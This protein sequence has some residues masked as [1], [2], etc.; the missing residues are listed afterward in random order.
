MAPLINTAVNILKTSAWIKPTNTSNI[1]NG[2]EANIGTK[3]ATIV[4]RTSPAK[5]LPKSRKEKERTFENSDMISRN[6]KKKFSGLVKL[7]N[8][9]R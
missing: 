4:N 9:L 6:P 8:F 2:K 7:T 1:I 3:K 5:I